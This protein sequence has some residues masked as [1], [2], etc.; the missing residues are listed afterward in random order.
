M[1]CFTT[2]FRDYLKIKTSVL[3]YFSELNDSFE[4]LEL[5]WDQERKF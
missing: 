5:K 4:Y 2:A 3:E 1:S